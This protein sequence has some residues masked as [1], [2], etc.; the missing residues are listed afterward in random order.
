[1]SEQGQNAAQGDTATKL[2]G[3]G[4]EL[5]QARDAAACEEAL[6]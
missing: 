1:M 3:L 6:A 4:I 5:R 2:E